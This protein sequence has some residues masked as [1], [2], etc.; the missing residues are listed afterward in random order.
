M[1]A[2][3]C[4]TG[5]SG[6]VWWYGGEIS[7]LD[8]DGPPLVVPP[9]AVDEQH[10]RR[11]ALLAE[12]V[13]PDQSQRRLVGRLDVGNPRPTRLSLGY[14]AGPSRRSGGGVPGE[15]AELVV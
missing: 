4:L 7:H 9:R 11:V 8:G 10:V 6:G 13:P 2:A 1:L 12:A 3:E 5:G 14:P 15:S